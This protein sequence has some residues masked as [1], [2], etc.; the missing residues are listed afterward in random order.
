MPILADLALQIRRKIKCFVPLSSNIL[1]RHKLWVAA[2][3]KEYNIMPHFWLSL[4]LLITSN[5][6]IYGVTQL[7]MELRSR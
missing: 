4:S 5:Q 1:G 7:I 2:E 3:I 6:K